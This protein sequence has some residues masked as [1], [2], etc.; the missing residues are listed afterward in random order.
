MKIET[1]KEKL[2]GIHAHDGKLV[3][4]HDVLP[5]PFCKSAFEGGC[6]ATMDYMV[7]GVFQCQAV[8][9]HAGWYHVSDWV[10]CVDLGVDTKHMVVFPKRMA[11]GKMKEILYATDGMTK[12][13]FS[14][15]QLESMKDGVTP[16]SLGGEM[17]LS[18]KPTK[19]GLPEITLATIKEMLH[20]KLKEPPKVLLDY[21]KTFMG[22]WDDK[23][24]AETNK[25][26]T[27]I[28]DKMTTD[29]Y[30]HKLWMTDSPYSHEGIVM[31]PPSYYYTPKFDGG[32]FKVGKGLAK[33][34]LGT[35]EEKMTDELYEQLYGHK[36][37]KPAEVPVVFRPVLKNP[38]SS[39]G[40]RMQK[41][42]EKG[43]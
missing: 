43:S 40:K 35:D 9:S 5:C 3:S 33:A 30:F 16:P 29:G 17:S 23:S 10:K 31:K 8:Y 20:K 22:D 11:K 39:W 42:L 6:A 1:L 21:Q 26:L 19:V 4:V 32:S 41:K 38:R 2:K 18:M 36:Y 37:G 34:M 14:W 12:T 27:E 7:T 24:I 13:P 25:K 15:N 28:V